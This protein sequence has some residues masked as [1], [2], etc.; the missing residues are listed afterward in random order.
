MNQSWIKVFVREKKVHTNDSIPVK[1]SNVSE[2]LR[3]NFLGV[4]VHCCSAM[5]HYAL[6]ST[7][8][9][10]KQNAAPF[11]KIQNTPSEE[12]HWKIIFKFFLSAFAELP[13]NL[14]T[15]NYNQHKICINILNKD[16]CICQQ[17]QRLRAPFTFFLHLWD[18]E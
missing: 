7:A 5:L 11:Q 3:T 14:D 9:G 2:Y 12:Y 10:W 4:Y 17:Q 13:M 16:S 8:S 15:R 6:S 1:S 18:I